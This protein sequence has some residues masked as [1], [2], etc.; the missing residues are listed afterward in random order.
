MQVLQLKH[1]FKR[2]LFLVKL[3][4]HARIE[5]EDSMQDA[6]GAERSLPW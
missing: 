6:I 3:V 4:M 2:L 5:G 1:E